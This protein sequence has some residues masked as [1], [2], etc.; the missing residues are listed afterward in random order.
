MTKEMIPMN[1]LDSTNPYAPPVSSTAD[2]QGS[3]SQTSVA[4][5]TKKIM[6]LI[7]KGREFGL[8]YKFDA[9]N[10]LQKYAVDLKKAG[11]NGKSKGFRMSAQLI[12]NLPAV[13]DAVIVT[14]CANCQSYVPERTWCSKHKCGFAPEGFCSQPDKIR[15]GENKK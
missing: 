15:T 1:N 9:I 5:K 11:S 4:D 8:V 13:K 12:A 7:E 6:S 2:N 10:I 14:R 3:D